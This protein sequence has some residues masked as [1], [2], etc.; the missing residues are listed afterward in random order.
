MCFFSAETHTSLSSCWR[1]TAPQVICT[2]QQHFLHGTQLS[3]LIFRHL[4][5]GFLCS[6]KGPFRGFCLDSE[7]AFVFFPLSSFQR[8]GGLLHHPGSAISPC[9]HNTSRV[10][11]IPWPTIRVAIGLVSLPAFLSRHPLETSLISVSH[12]RNTPTFL[13]CTGLFPAF[14]ITIHDAPSSPR[15]RTTATLSR[16]CLLL[17]PEFCC[18]IAGTSLSCGIPHPPLSL[19]THQNLR[20][21]S[22]HRLSHRNIG[23]GGTLIALGTKRISSASSQPRSNDSLT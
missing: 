1:D 13:V 10:P 20:V 12:R 14:S 18:S 21:F 15:R 4:L 5:E 6:I 19:P 9:L 23:F 17:P 16:V 22:P 3:C 8:K 2:F 11:G 7:D